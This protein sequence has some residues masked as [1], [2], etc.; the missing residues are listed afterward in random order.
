MQDLERQAVQDLMQKGA[1]VVETL[2]PNEFEERSP[3]RRHQHPAARHRD[4]GGTR[5]RQGRARH[6]LLLGLGL[7][8]EPPSRVAAREPRLRAGLRLHGRQARLAGGRAS[9]RGH[10]RR[11]SAGRRHRPSGRAHLSSPR[12][13]RGGPPAGLGRGLGCLRGG[14]RRT[15]RL[16]PAARRG[17]GEG[18]RRP[19]GSGDASG[20]EHVPA[21]CPDRGDGSLHG[22]PRARFIPDHN[23]RWATGRVAE[24]GR[25]NACRPPTARRPQVR[26][27]AVTSV[28]EPSGCT[29]CSGAIVACAVCDREG[30][31]HLLC[32][33]CVRIALGQEVPQPHG[34]GG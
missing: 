31:P 8:P 10:Q 21:P 15:R 14:E 18:E 32:Y 28:D 25:R 30:C 23:L 3:P 29:R 1:Q 24:G 34:H 4:R 9:H 22:P 19:R 16:R 26:G 12:G 27:S 33:R 2:P 5:A 20:I 13:H 7:R 17:A 11:Q 6:R